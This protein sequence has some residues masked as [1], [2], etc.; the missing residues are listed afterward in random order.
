M[1]SLA[2][3]T[4]VVSPA[5]RFGLDFEEWFIVIPVW[6]P[7]DVTS[8]R[9]IFWFILVWE[10]TVLWYNSLMFASAGVLYIYILMDT[11]SKFEALSQYLQDDERPQ[12]SQPQTFF[13]DF[14]TSE[15]RKSEL[16]SVPITLFGDK[17]CNDVD[18]KC[19]VMKQCIKD[20]Q[21]LRRHA[22]L[23]SEYFVAYFSAVYLVGMITNTIMAYAV[24]YTLRHTVL[25]GKIIS[26]TAM[27]VAY[28][29]GASGHIFLMCLNATLF[30]ITYD[31][32]KHSLWKNNW[33]EKSIE[34][35]EIFLNFSS[36]LNNSVKMKAFSF[37][38]VDLEH[39]SQAMNRSFSYFLFLYELPVAK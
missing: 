12:F 22:K 16:I 37:V 28:V 5:L 2:L 33:Y 29:A 14:E 8:S 23:I 30:E 4:A 15:G 24:V 27:Y 19:G 11:R 13:K 10:S 21:K 20:W 34:Y 38:S 35:R 1:Y 31:N 17:F 7:I 25:M 36:A 6:Y 26:E 18:R 3:F 32:L 39:F 9:R